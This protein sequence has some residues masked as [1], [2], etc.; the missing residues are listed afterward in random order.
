[1]VMAGPTDGSRACRPAALRA[2]ALA[3]LL[4]E[5]LAHGVFQLALAGGEVLRRAHLLAVVAVQADALELVA[6]RVA[7][8]GR[9]RPHL[10]THI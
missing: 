5:A 1:M 9:R 3:G 8:R 4:A 2:H 7:L 6:L 10:C